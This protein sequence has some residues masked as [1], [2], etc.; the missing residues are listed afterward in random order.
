MQRINRV[1]VQAT[2][3]TVPPNR[4]RRK[5]DC[6]TFLTMPDLRVVSVEKTEL[7]RVFRIHYSQ[8]HASHGG[9]WF[10]NEVGICYCPQI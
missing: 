5:E 10:S 2:L 4:Y 9:S 6:L 3:K 8:I 7:F 1:L